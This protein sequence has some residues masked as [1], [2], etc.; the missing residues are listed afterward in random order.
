M[1]FKYGIPSRLIQGPRKEKQSVEDD[2]VSEGDTLDS[3]GDVSY[4]NGF[5]A[6]YH[7]RH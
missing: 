5:S 1:V 4:S 2:T 6:V 3:D 7:L